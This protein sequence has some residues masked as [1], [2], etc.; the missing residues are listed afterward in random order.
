MIYLDD[1]TK[2][3]IKKN[4]QYNGIKKK[5]RGFK[6]TK[7]NKNNINCSENASTLVIALCASNTRINSR[8]DF[9]VLI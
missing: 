3:S 1:N 2:V 8:E 6:Q 7:T 5:K 9:K 4:V